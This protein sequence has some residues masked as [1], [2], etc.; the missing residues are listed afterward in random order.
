MYANKKFYGVKKKLCVYCKGWQA[1]TPEMDAWFCNQVL[2][3]HS[4]VHLLICLWVL[5]P[6]E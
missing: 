4:H 1:T 2:L 5:W 3:E 6:I